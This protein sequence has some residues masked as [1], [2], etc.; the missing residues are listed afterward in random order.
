MRTL[1]EQQELNDASLA[2]DKKPYYEEKHG[3]QDTLP[4]QYVADLHSH[5]RFLAIVF[6]ATFS[7]IWFSDICIRSA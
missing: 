1:G 3:S 2:F 6:G 4:L 5:E 7:D